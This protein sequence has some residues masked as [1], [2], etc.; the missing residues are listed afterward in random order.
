[1]LRKLKISTR[2]V[3]LIALMIAFIF[4][5]VMGFYIG[6]GN[7]KQYY[8]KHLQDEYTETQK[9]KILVGTH[10]M[11]VAISQLLKNV[12]DETEKVELIRGL[13]DELRYENDSSGYYF[14]Y[15]GTINVAHP[16]HQYYDKDLSGL[17]DVNGNYFIQDAYKNVQK[18][19]GFNYLVFDKPGK[20]DQPKI[21]YAEP[22]PNTEY[23]IASG[24]Y[25]DNIEETQMHLMDEVD[26]LTRE[27][28]LKVIITVLVVMLGV[29]LPLSIAIKRSIG[30]PLQKAI[31][32]TNEVANGN[33]TVDVTDDY[34]DEVS[35]L[36]SSLSRMIGKIET[37]A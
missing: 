16:G 5:T 9:E 37:S 14:V 23:W 1:M 33:L 28:L 31:D 13:I 20:G 4:I 27:M 18:G 35:E 12:E 24:V 30:L 6:I 3:I 34:N 19:G 8:T 25:I 2:L 7:L 29:A 15:K 32:I 21:V 36:N 10:S 22:I 11:A 17:V 26:A